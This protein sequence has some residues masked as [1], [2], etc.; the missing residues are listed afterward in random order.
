MMKNMQWAVKQMTGSQLS[1][2]SKA[3][4]EIIMTKL[5]MKNQISSEDPA[6]VPSMYAT[7]KANRQT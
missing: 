5:K 3:T 2:L 7:S 6:Q 1:L 4:T